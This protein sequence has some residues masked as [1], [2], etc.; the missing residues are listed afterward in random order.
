MNTNWQL[1]KAEYHELRPKKTKYCVLVPIINEGDRI[2]GQLAKMKKLTNKIDIILTDGGSTDG[3]TELSFLKSM[4]VR[5][6]IVKKDKGKLSAQLRL[7]LAYALIQG[8]DG[9]ITIDGNN[10]DG[11]DAISNFVSEIENGYDFIQGSRY[12][13]GGQA[14]NTPVIRNFA[15]KLIHA[16]VISLLTGSR[17]TDTT[18]GFR[19]FSRRYLLDPNVQPFRDIFETYELLA[20]LSVRADQLGFKTKEIP[21]TRKYP[22]DGMVPTKINSFRGNFE[23]ITILLKLA[24]KSFNPKNSSLI[25]SER[26]YHA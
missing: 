6:L 11:V 8:Y 15:I 22:D 26:N 16:P 4:C 20:Y 25:E 5:T 18:N 13:K 10:K 24:L 14:I 12:V 7:G 9:I 3:S 19:G 21:V 1:P 2:M 17:Y 23:L